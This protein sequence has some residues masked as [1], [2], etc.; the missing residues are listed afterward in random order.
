MRQSLP[1]DEARTKSDGG[2]CQVDE[3]VS[4][5]YRECIPDERLRSVAAHVRHRLADEWHREPI[6][7]PD[8]FWIGGVM[9][10]PIEP[11]SAN[12]SA[13]RRARGEAQPIMYRF[14]PAS[15]R[16][17]KPPNQ[18]PCAN[19]PAALMTA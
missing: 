2:M 16:S 15:A 13:I 1:A 17:T 5:K 12:M 4:G 3:S 9:N 8:L 19:L 14:A 18:S 10:N 6:C 7:D 11:P